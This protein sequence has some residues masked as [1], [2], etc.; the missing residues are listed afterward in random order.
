MTK[1]DFIE[2]WLGW[3]SFTDREKLK[4]EMENDLEAISSLLRVGAVTGSCDNCDTPETDQAIVKHDC[5]NWCLDCMRQAG[6]CIS[7][8]AYIPDLVEDYFNYEEDDCPACLASN[9]R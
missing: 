2:K 4:H 3:V 9:R 8:D 1:Q 7:C 6:H 5:E